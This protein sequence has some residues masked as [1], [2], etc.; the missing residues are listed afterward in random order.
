MTSMR[1]GDYLFTGMETRP[2][3]Y[4]MTINKVDQGKK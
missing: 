3:I 4:C 1:E 2:W